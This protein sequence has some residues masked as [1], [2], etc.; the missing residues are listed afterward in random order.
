MEKLINLRQLKDRRVWGANPRIGLLALKV[1]DMQ[2]E[3]MFL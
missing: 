1:G 2:R 3:F